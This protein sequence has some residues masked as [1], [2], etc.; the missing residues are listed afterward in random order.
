MLVPGRDDVLD[1]PLNV[2]VYLTPLYFS[3][4]ATSVGDQL[5]VVQLILDFGGVEREFS[6]SPLHATLIM[7]FE[8][9]SEV[10]KFA[11]LLQ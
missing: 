5:G 4:F 9:K 11:L 1:F 7:H 3:N 2:F 8:G 6:V 10:S